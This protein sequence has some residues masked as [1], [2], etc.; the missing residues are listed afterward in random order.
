LYC[1]DCR[2]GEGKG[3]KKGAIDLA[4][5]FLAERILS[6]AEGEIQ[7]RGGTGEREMPDLAPA[8]VGKAYF[9]MS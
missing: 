8:I 7:R 2:K 9:M 3:E 6:P 1:L 4:H 5:A